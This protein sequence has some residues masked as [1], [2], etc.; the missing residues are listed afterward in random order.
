[1]FYLTFLCPYLFCQFHI[2]QVRNFEIRLHCW[3]AGIGTPFLYDSRRTPQLL[4]QPVIGSFLLCKDYF[5]TINI[6][7]CFVFLLMLNAKVMVFSEIKMFFSFFCV[8]ST[9]KVKYA[10]KQ[11]LF[12]LNFLGI[13]FILIFFDYIDNNSNSIF[14][15]FLIDRLQLSDGVSLSRSYKSP[16]VMF[17]IV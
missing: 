5:D 3:L 14:L 10:A 9:E 15:R 16:R 8:F 6:F 13:T 11:H 1:M 12:L 17:L 7:H 2:K 4:H